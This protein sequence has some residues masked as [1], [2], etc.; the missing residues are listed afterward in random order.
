MNQIFTMTAIAAITSATTLSLTH[1]L[2][3]RPWCM[4]LEANGQHHILYGQVECTHK[5]TSQWHYS[6][7]FSE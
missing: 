6:Q 3:S 1:H 5:H 2:L 4:V 7:K